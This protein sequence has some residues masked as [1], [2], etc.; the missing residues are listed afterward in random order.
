MK[1]SKEKAYLKI[2]QLFSSHTE[3]MTRA[4]DRKQT[5]RS[6]INVSDRQIN[7]LRRTILLLKQELIRFEQSK[8]E[9]VTSMKIKLGDVQK[10]AE[11]K[12]SEFVNVQT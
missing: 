10:L 1:I 11:K 3:E 9:D 12:I 5:L 2:E 6:K 7:D 4:R 8:D